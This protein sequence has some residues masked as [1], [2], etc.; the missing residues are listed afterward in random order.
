MIRPEPLSSTSVVASASA[1][2]LP[3][4]PALPDPEEPPEESTRWLAGPPRAMLQ[5]ERDVVLLDPTRPEPRV[6][7][8][9]DGAVL[10]ANES[11]DGKLLGVISKGGSLHLYR[12]ADGEK[13]Q[14]IPC[15]HGASSY[16]QD[17]R[18]LTFRADGKLVAALCK[19]ARVFEV[20]T[21]KEV[22]S[23]PKEHP[24]ALAFHADTSALV[25]VGEELRVFDGTSFAPSG[26]P[27][28]FPPAQGPLRIVLSPDGRFVAA[29]PV[30]AGDEKPKFKALLARTSP[31]AV[32]GPLAPE[33]DDQGALLASF[34]PDGSAL[35]LEK[36]GTWTKVIAPS[37]MQARVRASTPPTS[38]YAP[39]VTPD[40]ERAFVYSELGS[41]VVEV[42]TGATVTKIPER[43]YQPNLISPDGAYLLEPGRPG[44]ILRTVSDGKVLLRFGERAPYPPPEQPAE[45][46]PDAPDGKAKQLAWMRDRRRLFAW[47]DR[48]AWLVDT[49]EGTAAEVAREILPLIAVQPSPSGDTWA[50][51]GKVGIELRSADGSLLRRIQAPLGGQWDN[52]ATAISHDGKRLAHSGDRIRVWDTETG[53]LLLVR[54]RLVHQTW[55]AAFTPD[56]SAVVFVAPSSFVVMDA[57]N[58]KL[59]GEEHNT[60]TGATFPCVVSPDGR[61]VGAGANN[62][63]TARVWST[64]PFRHAAD[65]AT[66]RDCQNHTSPFFQDDGRRVTA[67]S[68]GEIQVFEVGTWKRLGKRPFA[69]PGFHLNPSDPEG[70][71]VLL[72][73]DEKEPARIAEAS[74]GRVV[75]KLEG[76][77]GETFQF[78]DDGRRIA[79]LMG[80]E[81]VVRDTATGKITRRVPLGKP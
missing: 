36:Y 46:P 34:S 57:D 71:L 76:P 63:H 55:S 19:E 49:Q 2:A 45:E 39:S 75:A 56:R 35:F 59:F 28:S 48:A 69:D 58:G 12:T 15:A 1:S 61:W 3:P 31:A 51:V 60:G 66:A 78:S 5:R 43:C 50:L 6:L 79:D 73:K 62:G 7:T 18:P 30:P 77:T 64:F 40:G 72:W 27:L 4:P 52:S 11:P 47:G 26:K 54:P 20:E 13:I 38:G 74:S 14:T 81:L 70:K 25:T 21:G 22:A 16:D 68:N 17:E 29:T 8:P 53:R 42:K 65:L 33:E 24:T 9:E 10:H 32:L 44:A 23:L 80:G 37:S 67:L 41:W